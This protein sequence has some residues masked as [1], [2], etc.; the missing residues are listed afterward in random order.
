VPDE[1]FSG[2][3]VDMGTAAGGGDELIVVGVEDDAAPHW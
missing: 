3:E 2:L 1:A